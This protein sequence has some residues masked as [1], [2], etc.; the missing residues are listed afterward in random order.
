ML[1]FLKRRRRRRLREAPFPEEWRQI[2]ETNIPLFG[3]LSENDRRELLGNVQVFL[4]E[5]H[6]E[7]CGS[8]QVT[9]EIRVTVAAQACMLLLHRDTDFYPGL[10]AILVYPG[11]YMAPA[12]EHLPGGVV[13]EGPS[14]R[15]GESWNRGVVV[16][17]WDDVRRGASDMRDGQNLVFHEFAHQLDLESGAAEGA[18]GFEHRSSYVAWA[19]VLGQEYEQLLRDVATGH[20]NVLDRYGA[21]NP[22]EFFAVTTEAFFEKPLELRR[23]HPELYDELKAFYRQD[24]AMFFATDVT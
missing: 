24:P 5:K 19:R 1:G 10:E 16:L 6:F 21:T 3:R 11:A 15:L 8:L 18:P 23:Q 2:I 7:G 4:A 14:A 13:R 9:D 12:K 17:S 20:A 22:A